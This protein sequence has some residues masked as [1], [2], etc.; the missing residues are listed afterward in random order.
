[1]AEIL[2]EQGAVVARLVP[3]L[4][5]TVGLLYR[6]HPLTPSARAFVELA[7]AT[8]GR[9]APGQGRRSTAAARKSSN[10]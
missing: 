8:S 7:R 5:R 2:G 4:T 3:A 9:R 10:D 1:M 6:A